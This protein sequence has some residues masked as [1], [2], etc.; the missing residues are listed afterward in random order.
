MTIGSKANRLF[1]TSLTAIFK[2]EIIHIRRNPATLTF[3]LLF[4]I[5]EL[6]LLGFILDVNVKQIKTVVYDLS[7]TQ[8]SKK[9]IEQF[10]ST[11]DFNIVEVVNND[12]AFYQSVKDGR[13]KV[14]LKIPADYAN[15]LIDRE[16]AS[17][18]VIVDGSNATVSGEAINVSNRIALEASLDR[19]LEQL[20][21]SDTPPVQTRTSVLF[22]PTTRSANFFLPGLLVWELPSVTILL[23]ALSIVGEKEKGTLEQL[24]ITPFNPAGLI[25]GKMIPYAI[26]A[27]LLLCEIL[28]IMRYIFQVP[29]NGSVPLLIAFTIPFILASLGLGLIISAGA[30]NQ[31]EAM[32]MGLT[33]RVI[34]PFYFTGYFF[35]LESSPELFQTFTKIIPERYLMEI[36]RAIILRG[37]GFEHLWVHGLVLCLMSVVTLSLATIIYKKKFS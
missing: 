23:V 31:I 26:L 13:A 30:N 4:P 36:T 6:L 7:N 20:N 33:F 1:W 29:I 22:N 11:Y 12:E 16:T 28:F 3:A 27:F 18:L 19:I 9:L 25:L 34:P 14:G 10:V 5:L 8:D 21:N 17:V 24:S 37:A 35:P 15:N 2:K 32:Q